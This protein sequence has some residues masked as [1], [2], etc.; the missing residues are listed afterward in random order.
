MRTPISLQERV[1]G[2]F[3]GASL[4]VL[5]S[6][7][8]AMGYRVDLLD[9]FREG[10][11]LYAAAREGH[12]AVAGSPVKVLGVEMGSVTRVDLREDP[13]FPGRPVRLTIRLRSSAL[14]FLSERMR[15]VIVE[16][17]LGSGMPPFGTAAVELRAD[18][19]EGPRG[20]LARYSTLVAESEPSMVQAMT[21]M[22]G[23]VT[24]LRAEMIKS[25]SAMGSTFTNLHHLTE[26]LSRGDG[27]AGRMMTDSKLA[28]DL[29]ATLTEA[30]ATSVD[31]RR[32]VAEMNRVTL[33]FPP[34]IDATRNLAVVSQK[35]LGRLDSTLDSLPRLL[36]STERTLA[37][38]EELVANLRKTSGY[39][40]ELARKVDVSLE[41]TH[42]LVEAA[43]K[44]LLLRGNLPERPTL[45][46]EAEVRPPALLPSASAPRP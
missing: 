5:M 38:S 15:A 17:P 42:R 13:A 46:T 9:A 39:A 34:A 29:E 31:L 28:S 3:V 35:S 2:L 8:L 33:K 40:P 19:P 12:G 26:A 44:N 45:R 16:P 10:F 30:R 37:A 6:A 25:I 43:Q 1:V 32:L 7:V 14:P 41:E 20:T 18:E 36:A 4:L 24:L 23:D 22:A 11:V 27:L 21:R